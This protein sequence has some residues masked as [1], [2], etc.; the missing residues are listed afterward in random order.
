MQDLLFDVSININHIQEI[1]VCGCLTR[2]LS[3]LAEANPAYH[4]NQNDY[5]QNYQSMHFIIITILEKNAVA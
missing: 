3:R 2:W 4:K 5:G 1:S